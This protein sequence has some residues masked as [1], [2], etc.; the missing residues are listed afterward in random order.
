MNT[1][2]KIVWVV[3]ISLIF[4]N[5]IYFSFKL[6]FPQLKIKKILNKI[7][8]TSKNKESISSL[9]TLFISLAS[10]LGAGS[11]SGIALAIYY[12][13]IGTIFWIWISTLFTSINCYLE[14]ILAIKYKEKD[15]KYNKGGPSYYINKGLGKKKLSIIYAIL[16]IAAYI[17]GFI[18]IQNNTITTL[19][20]NTYNCSSII[21]TSII[22]ILS[23]IFIFKGIKT[24]SKAC[25]K[26]VPIMTAIYIILGIIVLIKNL[27]IMPLLLINIV[28]D[29]FSLKSVTGGIISSFII[30]IQKSI[31]ASEAGV[32][33]SA[34]ASATSDNNDPIKQ[35]YYGIIETFFIN[36]VITTIT[37]LMIITSNF[38]IL[39]LKNIN[40][41]E[42]TNFAFYFHFGNIGKFFLLTV[43]ILFCFS[44][45]ITCYYYGESNLKILTN[46]KKTIF[47]LK[48]FTIVILF[49]G[50]IAKSS[51]VWT[52]GDILIGLLSIINIYAIN[53]LE[54]VIIKEHKNNK[55]IE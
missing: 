4:L 12:G 24:I 52:T 5:G 46:N 23:T 36:F 35:G 21:I 19:I 6:K 44:T 37:A 16:A 13:G 8:N 14:N 18:T 7:K 34:I 32:G 15:G 2:N 53:K 27:K 17:I 33:T 48:I 29:A 11:L 30:G 25:N 9:D 41:I 49:I 28:K 51:F 47:L 38:H 20:T 42:I 1:I 26:I 3:A 40:G 31:F 22:T 54:S 43:L 39:N 55:Y 45:I 10:K 50:G